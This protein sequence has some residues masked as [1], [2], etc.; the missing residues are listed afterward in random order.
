[1]ADG[2]FNLTEAE[3]LIPQLESWLSTA[4][5]SRK[6]IGVIEDE[7]SALLNRLS[8]SGGFSLDVGACVRR[9]QEKEQLISALRGAAQE[10]ENSGCLLKDLDIGLIDFPCEWEGREVYL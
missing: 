4:I 1:M 2:L 6:K 8:L 10:I 5:D 9:K 3:R 7:E